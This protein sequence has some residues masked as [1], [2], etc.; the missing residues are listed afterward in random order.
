MPP[1]GMLFLILQNH[2][3][4]QWSQAVTGNYGAPEMYTAQTEM[5]CEYKIFTRY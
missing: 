5:C 1:G 2:A 3:A 4:Q